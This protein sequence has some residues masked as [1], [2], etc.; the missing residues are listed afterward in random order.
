MKDKIIL[1]AKWVIKAPLNDVFN[2]M[3]DFE[4]WPEYFPKVA[5]SI[6]ITARVENNFELTATVKSFGQKFPVKMKT[7]ILS[8]KGF[9][10]DNESPK[11][12]TSGHE[13]LLLSENPDGTEIDYTYEVSIHKRWLRI[14]A[15]PL[16][17][18]FSMKYWQKA[19]I[20]ELRKRLEK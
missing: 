8:G 1:H 18:W 20:D 9:I 14:I 4:K 6:Q 7:R 13:E 11:F 12:G 19:V 5:Q 10:S 16:I 3:T 2:V 15:K 17:G